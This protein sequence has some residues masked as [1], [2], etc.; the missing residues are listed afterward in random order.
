MFLEE[1]TCL[2]GLLLLI[3]QPQPGLQIDGGHASLFI[4]PAD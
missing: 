3:W 4:F 2:R 1:N